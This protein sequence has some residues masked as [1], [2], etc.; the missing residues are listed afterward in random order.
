MSSFT[1]LT[2]RRDDSGECDLASILECLLPLMAHL[3]RSGPGR[4]RQLCPGSTS[5]LDFL[6]D[7]NG[8]VNLNPKI[9]NR[10]LDLG[11]AQ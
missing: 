6:R 7:L 8:V 5:D 2:R 11:M 1:P 3:H 9:S 10:A 4:A